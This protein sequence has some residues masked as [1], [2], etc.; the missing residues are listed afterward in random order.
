MNCSTSTDVVYIDFSKAFDSIVFSKLLHKLQWYGISGNLLRWISQFLHGRTQSVVL[1]G[2]VSSICN[3][4][5]GVPQGSVLG[6]LLFLIFINDICSICEN[7][8]SMKLFADDAKLYTEIR[9]NDNSLQR[10]LNRLSVWCSD[11]QPTINISKC[12]GLSLHKHT[13]SSSVEVNY[14]IN[15]TSINKAEIIVDLGI[16]ITN[17]LDFKT[18]VITHVI[19]FLRL[20]KELAFFLE[21]LHHAIL[22]Y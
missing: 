18:H 12:C 19:L 7:D 20:C 22:I 17:S 10:S 14:C 6:P 8:V 5:S 4:T 2:S 13:V 9:L 3:V 16:T 11:W 1:D 15:G 21:V